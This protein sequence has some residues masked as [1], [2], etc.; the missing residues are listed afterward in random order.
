MS[1]VSPATLNTS[2]DTTSRL[3]CCD[4]TKPGEGARVVDSSVHLESSTSRPTPAGCL[5]G[6][7]VASTTAKQRGFTDRLASCGN[8]SPVTDI[9]PA[10][11]GSSEV[12]GQ[13][14]Q[15]ARHSRSESGA[16][17]MLEAERGPRCPSTDS[18]GVTA[19]PPG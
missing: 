7:S 2:D 6:G 8:G 14:S 1:R 17:Q 19:N 3:V 9:R 15:K 18:T 13:R 16:C 10:A 5:P 11:A 4:G 12:G